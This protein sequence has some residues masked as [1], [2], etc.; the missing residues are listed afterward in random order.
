MTRRISLALIGIG[1]LAADLV[2]ASPKVG[3]VR[4]VASSGSVA[5]RTPPKLLVSGLE[6]DELGKQTTASESAAGRSDRK[7]GVNAGLRGAPD[8]RLELHWSSAPN[9]FGAGTFNFNGL[10]PCST[11]NWVDNA[12]HAVRNNL[13]SC[14]ATTRRYMNVT[15]GQTSARQASVT[16]YNSWNGSTTDP[17]APGQYGER[18]HCVYHF[19]DANGGQVKLEY[20]KNIEIEYTYDGVN[21]C[22]F[23][24]GCDGVDFSG[25]T[26]FN[27]QSRTGFIGSTRITSGN[28]AVD[29]IVGSI[30]L[31][32][33][34]ECCNSCQAGT[35]QCELNDLILDLSRYLSRFEARMSV[36]DGVNAVVNAMAVVD[37]QSALRLEISDTCIENGQSQT[38]VEVW[39]RNL[40]QNATGFQAFIA[41]DD[42]KFNYNGGASSYT[43]AP[44]PQHIQGLATAQIGTGLL[45]IDGST[46]PLNPGT[47]ADAK[48]ATLVFDVDSGGWTQCETTFLNFTS[49]GP[50]NSELSFN[51][52]PIPTQLPN[53]AC[54][55][56]DTVAPVIACPA[57][58]TV[59]CN[60]S[61]DPGAIIT[62]ALN[63]FNSNPVLGPTQAP[64][65][66]YT[67]RYPP[68]G[69][70]SEF[71][72]GDNRLKH[73]I[74]A[75]DCSPCRPGGFGSAF[76]DTQ[77]RKYDIAGTTMMSIDLY[78]PAAW[79]TTGRRMAGFWGT[80]FDSV[81]AV[82]S[83]PI[84]E[85][86]SLGG[87]P[88]FRGW[89]NAVGD[90]IDMGLPTGFSY[91]SWHRLKIELVGTNWRYT[92]GDLVLV[93]SATGSVNIG[94]VI[95]Q[96][97]N[98][99][100]GVTYDIYW[101]N[102]SSITPT[103][104]TTA[105]DNCD[106]D[107][108]ITY[109]D[110]PDLSGCNGTGTILRTWTATDACGNF[111]T[112]VQTINVIDTVAP[113]ITCP[114]DT[115]VECGDSTDPADTGS[116]TAIDACDPSP[117]ISYSDASAGTC[118]R[119]I[120]RTWKAT[121]ACGNEST[122]VQLITVQ[123]TTV[124]TISFC[125]DDVTIECHVAPIPANTGGP[126]TASDVCDPSPVVSFTDVNSLG[127]CNGTGTITRTWIATDVCGNVSAPCV[128]VITVVDTVAPTFTFCPEDTTIE[129]SEST[130]PG[131]PFGTATGGVMIYYNS[132]G[133]EAPNNQAYFKSQFSYGNANGSQFSF[134]SLPL[135][136]YGPLT[137]SA[138]FGQVGPPS[139]FGFDLELITPTNN[140]SVLP[141]GLTAYE[142]TNNGVSGRL[143][144][145][146]VLWKI[147]D[148]K[149]GS[150][151]GPSNA[152]NVDINSLIRSPSPGNPFTDIVI[153]QLDVSQS[154]P[155]YTAQVAGKLK[156]DNILHWYTI[157][158]PDTPM[159]VYGLNGEFYFWGTLTYDS[160]GD[161]GSDRKDFYEGTITISANSPS[162]GLGF[163]L[164]T[165]NCTLFPVISY[166]DEYTAGGDCPPITGTIERT[167][168]ATDACGNFSTC[169]QM[170]T[171]V[172]STAP[173]ITCPADTT[174]ECG[175][176]TLPSNTG[177]ANALD[178]C[179]DAPG[180][181]Y[182]D[183]SSGSCP[184]VITR[185]WTATDACGNFSTC[186]QT[187]T[188]QDTTPP[189]V[190]PPADQTVECD[191]AGNLAAFEAWQTGATASDVC[192][193]ALPTAYV[194]DSNVPG[195]GGTRVVTAHWT[196]TDDCGNI[197]S[198]A[199][200][201]F[202]IADTT[203]PT[204]VCPDD[205]V[206]NA[207]P[208]GCF[209]SVAIVEAT[210]S[211]LCSG[212]IT[213]NGARDDLAALTDP[214]PQ[215]VTTITWTATDECGLSGTCEQT[216][217]VNAVNSFEIPVLLDGV[218]LGS[219]VQRCIQ[220][221]LKDAS[222][223]NAVSI[224]VQ[225]S[226]DGAAPAYGLATFT[227]S[228]SS[229]GWL[230]ICAK[231]E[232]HT[233]SDK[234]PLT[235]AGGPPY[236]TCSPLLLLAGDTD[237]DNDVDINDVTLL[238]VQF[239]SLEA[240]G[241]CPWDGTRGADFDLNGAIGS[242]DYTALSANWL[243]Y[244]SC[245]GP[246]GWRLV[247][248]SDGDLVPDLIAMPS[249]RIVSTIDVSQLAP[250]VAA[251]ADLNGDRVIDYHDVEVFESRMGLPNDLSTRM[252]SAGQPANAAMTSE[253][254][255]GK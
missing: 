143:A 13:A 189:V 186:T 191:G 106:P 158:Q 14:G 117:V 107:P 51:G 59:Q 169:T 180:V 129:C 80:G 58:T 156:S 255:D 6:Q 161:D 235:I 212:P 82:S 199:S 210:G 196:A 78:V 86:T 128:Q 7:A 16:C 49:N 227:A 35:E 94:N 29:E 38:I 30:G 190:T 43:A 216:V 18:M 183:S 157:G 195:C 138:L 253:R 171:V 185:V 25:A 139:Q 87:T 234:R 1:L 93:T 47:N 123:D 40:R 142:N 10:S 208:G 121:D 222:S 103:Q 250:D 155:I 151:S 33:V 219:P 101:D 220:F 73:S 218:S 42:S 133:P 201:T 132:T 159:P 55:K 100:A 226:F 251:L 79:A 9:V 181:G 175:E 66:W 99:A 163:A 165:D 211:D 77:G 119:L 134:S 15:S 193:G 237:N 124:P 225:V 71:F 244:Q 32:F 162:V 146:A 150:P 84:I 45:R 130:V 230:E 243:Q 75:S 98:N 254:V 131:I 34:P 141:A 19:F 56:Y 112:C 179:D 114:P 198:S 200:R 110:S 164:A 167:W 248:P 205:I 74:S 140:G 236:Y 83:F 69:F 149:D 90:W 122:C 50:F 48:L 160:T 111:S 62:K 170:I 97:H 89:N 85:F 95:L 153:T 37:F 144:A 214:Y 3:E 67:D 246:F 232:Q 68:A 233:L 2:Q 223:C 63:A 21:Y 113:D 27:G 81:P 108:S 209:A 207:D 148:Y 136:G 88:R 46:L 238:L 166:E 152:A 54:I 116:A 44:F 249:S 52:T 126:A 229:T 184:E 154:G 204:V 36:D 127:G 22:T 20:L 174:I 194:E 135:T 5:G 8:Y 245:C 182:T 105:T 26:V 173:V 118:P 240:S 11:G 239:G 57:D 217:T 24:L 109:S 23:T 178:N 247:A 172:D 145:G 28:A 60:D 39:M 72:D 4:P 125:P 231:D 228:C 104:P 168:K 213:I 197:G 242:P 187:I 206:V 31:A 92:V 221:V 224:D 241:G 64:E 70:I 76:Y 215:G 177:T 188:V 192:S 17:L 102:F 137:W 203:P 65:V 176:S 91:D 252:R 41:F 12:E 147:A 120:S 61:I 202:T 115:T 96:G 53:S